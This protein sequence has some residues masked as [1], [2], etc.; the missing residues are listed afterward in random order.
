[1]N[2]ASIYAQVLGSGFAD[3]APALKRLH[4]QPIDSEERRFRG[5]LTVRTGSHPLVRLLLWAGRLPRTQGEAP[6]DLCLASLNHG[7][8]WQR[9]IGPWKFDTDQCTAFSQSNLRR[10]IRERFGIITLGLHLRVKRGGL[11]IRSVK[12]RILGI[13]LPGRLGIRVMA[14]EKPVNDDSFSCNVRVY[15]PGLPS[16]LR[17]RGRLSENRQESGGVCCLNAKAD[18]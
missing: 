1:M 2:P 5:V 8:R 13:P 16:F 10:E 17:Y 6:C 12:T 18:R 11:C 14:R 4:G 15:L 3:L 9:K 7:E